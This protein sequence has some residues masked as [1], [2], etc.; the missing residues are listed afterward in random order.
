MF[1]LDENFLARTVA[2]LFMSSLQ[3]G[4]SSV[5][6][7]TTTHRHAMALRFRHEGI[8][9]NALKRKGRYIEIDSNEILSGCMSGRKLNKTKL[10]RW[11]GGAVETAHAAQ[12]TTAKLTIFGGLVALLWAKR[13]VEN[14]RALESFGE[15]LAPFPYTLVCGYPM[16][17][18]SEPG[19]EASFLQ[20]CAMHSTV[21]PPDAFPTA[22]AER[23]ILSAMAHSYAEAKRK[24]HHDA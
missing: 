23:R 15:H 20:I 21:I 3:S 18:F 4:G 6:I 16:K 7:S 24:P 1:Y 9:L 22:E 10:N 13:D 11:I 8:D 17:E 2:D 19:T 12:T 14:I 5:V